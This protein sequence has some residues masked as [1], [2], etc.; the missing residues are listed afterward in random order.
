MKKKLMAWTAILLLYTSFYASTPVRA[1]FWGGDLP[2]L[3]QIVVNTLQQLSQLR[4]IFSNGRDT[5]GLLRD[6]NEGI[7]EA[8]GIMR[9]L[10]TTIKPGVLSQY[11]NP[12]EILRYLQQIYGSVPPTF[13]APA[14]AIA[15]QSVAEAVTLHNQAFDYADIVDPEAERIKDYSRGVS[16][17]GAGRLTA[18]SLGVLIHVSNQILRTNAAMLKIMSQHLALQNRHEKSNSLQYQIQYEGLSDAL[19][20]LPKLSSSAKLS[21]SGSF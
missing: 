13:N 16:P 4:Q 15:D 17:A 11:K 8:M 2:L 5:L 18:Q 7:R 10:N 9:T 6:I 3:T 1:D 14:E 20:S 21:T 12:E 19:N